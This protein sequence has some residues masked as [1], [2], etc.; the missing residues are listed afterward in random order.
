MNGRI[1]VGRVVNSNGIYI[2]Y[3]GNIR[4]HRGVDKEDRRMIVDK[5]GKYLKKGLRNR[6]LPMLPKAISDVCFGEIQANRDFATTYTIEIVFNS[7]SRL[8][9]GVREMAGRV[10]EDLIDSIDGY[11][12]IRSI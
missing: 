5:I 9:A 12:E 4:W 2:Y 7:K 6:L 8:L 3:R 10:I 11:P 1:T